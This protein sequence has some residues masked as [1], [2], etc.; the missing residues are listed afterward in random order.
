METKDYFR[1]RREQVR[2]ELRSKY[3]H[4]GNA[5]CRAGVEHMAQ[6]CAMDEA[7]LIQVRD[8][9]PV[10]LHIIL[11]ERRRYMNFQKQSKEGGYG[12]NRGMRNMCSEEAGCIAAESDCPHDGECGY[13][14][15]V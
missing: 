7:G 9:G 3:Q 11:E 12:T 10:A 15:G 1:A 5:L 13:I 14:E 2:P 4:I 6:L 8:I